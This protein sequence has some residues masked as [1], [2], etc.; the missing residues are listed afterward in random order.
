MPI[1]AP[2]TII[3]AAVEP[4]TFDTLRIRNFQVRS[5]SHGIG[6]I[7]IETIPENSE[8]HETDQSAPFDDIRADLYELLANVPSAL[9]VFESFMTG[10]DAALPD[11]RAYIAD[12]AAQQAVPSAP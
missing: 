8:T 4:K 12:K 9:A 3:T 7:Y 2:N 1:T 10:M 5:A 11:I 6:S